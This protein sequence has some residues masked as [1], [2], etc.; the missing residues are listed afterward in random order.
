MTQ[1]QLSKVLF[2]AVENPMFQ[3]LRSGSTV[4]NKPNQPL[5]KEGH[6]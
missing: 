5:E 6:D 3:P 4:I 1:E 2:K